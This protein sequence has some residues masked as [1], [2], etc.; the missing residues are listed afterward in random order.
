MGYLEDGL[1]VT[2]GSWK[3]IEGVTIAG[4][5]PNAAWVFSLS[6]STDSRPGSHHVHSLRLHMGAAAYRADLPLEISLNGQQFESRALSFSYFH[7]PTLLSVSPQSGPLGG[8]TLVIVSGL[9]LASGAS[10]HRCR[11]SVAG[12]AGNLSSA[13]VTFVDGTL[14]ASSAVV[15]CRSPAV[16]AAGVVGLG[17]E[18]SRG[19]QIVA[20]E[21]YD[22]ILFA[23]YNVSVL[24]MMAPASG[25]RPTLCSKSSMSSHRICSHPIPTLLIASHLF[26]HTTTH[27]TTHHPPIS[28]PILH[29]AT[30]RH[31]TPTHLP[32]ASYPTP[33]PY[34][35]P[36]H[37]NSNKLTSHCPAPQSP[38]PP[39]PS[40]PCPVTLVNPTTPRSLSSAALFSP[41][42]APG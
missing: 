25:V 40:P 1:H 37:L 15:S 10:Q 31:T 19:G 38:I 13:N 14:D 42:R 34:T 29:H 9:A 7:S 5:E 36:H 23:Y 27:L 39:C 20:T 33:T 12:A 32:P 4:W 30:P 22:Q 17:I 6:A 24:P 35:T 2:L 11:F 3:L 16:Y 41:S 18:L 28:H 8:D 21:R 26:S